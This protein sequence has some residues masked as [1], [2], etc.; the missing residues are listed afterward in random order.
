MNWLLTLILLSTIISWAIT[1]RY[2]EEREKLINKHKKEIQEYEEELYA[3]LNQ[4][5]ELTN[6]L[7]EAKRRQ[8]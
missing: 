6:E 2:Q 4:N 1:H 5:L 8:Y 7:A 3:A